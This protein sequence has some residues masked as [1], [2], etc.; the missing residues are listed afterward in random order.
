MIRIG[1]ILIDPSGA[2]V[3]RD[4]W[5]RRGSPLGNP[6]TV[7]KLGRA[8]AVAAYE[9]RF[10]DAIAAG[11]VVHPDIFDELDRL[12]ALHRERGDLTLTCWCAPKRCHAE[13]I[14][15]WLEANP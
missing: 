14:K 8:G 10:A 3:G 7:A 6:Y 9:H 1:N 4:G 13:I 2:Y 15:R 11:R 5:G 12:R